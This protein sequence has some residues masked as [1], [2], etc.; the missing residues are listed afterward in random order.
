MHALVRRMQEGMADL[1]LVAERLKV[2]SHDASQE[3]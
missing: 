1:R 2:A 3:A